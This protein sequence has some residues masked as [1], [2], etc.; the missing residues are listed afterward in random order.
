M[1]RAKRTSGHFFRR[2]HRTSKTRDVHPDRI[3]T[4]EKRLKEVASAKGWRY[5]RDMNSDQFHAW[6]AG[7]VKR[8][9]RKMSAAVYNSYVQVAVSFGNWLIGKRMYG[10]RSSL[11]GEKRLLVNPFAGL[12]K[13]DERAMRIR[14]ARALTEAELIRLLDAARRRPLEDALLIR[15]GP[16][17]GSM[18]AKVSA[19]RRVTL[20]KLGYER[21]LIYKTAIL[22]G[23]L[24]NELTTLKVGCLS[25][26]DI[27]VH[28][29]VGFQRKEPKGLYDRNSVRLGGRPK[30]LGRG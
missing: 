7:E 2:I 8:P 19:S 27:P 11:N 1:V 20:I 23:L 13:L 3:K 30:S 10:K 14:M 29:L 18:V 17:A 21:A 4:T 28:P 16:N 9:D 26:G 6:L 24:L 25:F 22:T 5:L 15:K 12:G